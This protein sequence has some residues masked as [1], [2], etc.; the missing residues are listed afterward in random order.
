MIEKVGLKFATKMA[1]MKASRRRRDGEVPLHMSVDGHLALMHDKIIRYMKTHDSDEIMGL[2]AD[3]LL[4]LQAA[5]DASGIQEPEEPYV[6]EVIS[7]LSKDINE[8][9]PEELQTWQQD[10]HVARELREYLESTGDWE[11]YDD[12]I[13]DEILLAEATNVEEKDEEE[14]S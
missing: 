3:S 11:K 14:E 10:H 13:K 6:E 2:A 9:L 7:S 12:D 5:L 4:A 1:N 8:L